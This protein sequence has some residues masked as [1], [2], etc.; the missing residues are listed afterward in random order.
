MNAIFQDTYF[1]PTE[2]V[3]IAFRTKR[4]GE[5]VIRFRWEKAPGV[6]GCI[7]TGFGSAGFPTVDAA[8][9]AAKRHHGFQV[10]A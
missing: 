5:R 2:V 6:K 1:G 3:V 9:S 7:T 10:A 8:I 4:D